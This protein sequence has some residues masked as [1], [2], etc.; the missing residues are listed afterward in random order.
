MFKKHNSHTVSVA[1]ILALIFCKSASS[2]GFISWYSD[3]DQA[4]HRISLLNGNYNVFYAN[5]IDTLP[6]Y[7]LNYSTVD[8]RLPTKGDHFV[9]EGKLICVFG[10]TGSIFSMDTVNR[11]IRRL[12][13]TSHSGYNFD[14][15]QFERRDTIFSFG[16]YGFWT[17]NNLLT[18]FSTLRKEWNVYS[19]GSFPPYNPDFSPGPTYKFA[20][21]DEGED[22]LYVLR[23]RTFYRYT[24]SNQMWGEL[25]ELVI[26]NM[27]PEKGSMGISRLHRM[28][29]STVMMMGGLKAFYVVPRNNMIYDVT[30][31]NGLN[32]NASRSEN[33]FGFH[34]GYDLENEL[35]MAKFSDK[36]PNGYL[37][38]YVNRLPKRINS[39]SKLY[40]TRVFTT[41]AKL[42]FSLFGFLLIGGFL[43]YWIRTLY[44]KRRYQYFTEAQWKFIQRLDKG[45]LQTEDL[46]EFLELGSSSW[47][48]QRRKRSE[49][50]KMIN[51]LCLNQLG[52][53]LVL[54]Q[55]SK[56]DK[57]QVLYV[58]NVEA[59]NKLARLM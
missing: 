44:L 50:I 40:S 26:D 58:M 1:L 43:T 54:R 14:A 47:E 56:E 5:H 59:K 49:Y 6:Q 45:G 31:P 52:C 32:A 12:D 11:T 18:Y 9:S 16:G 38:E 17:E 34:C 53:E 28:N 15:Y 24:F 22:A 33:P 39:Q 25:G 55:R 46:N 23:Q 36:L 48:V 30:L 57:R 13:R 51:D 7:T 4:V 3:A 10:G 20:F 19:V 21:Y 41:Q 2:K 42:G 29:D 37:F 27:F 8:L 35:V